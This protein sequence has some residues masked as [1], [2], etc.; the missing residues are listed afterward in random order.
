MTLGSLR[1]CISL[2]CRLP[3]V[4]YMGRSG[5]RLGYS[6]VC[7]PGSGCHPLPTSSH[8]ADGSQVGYSPVCLP[9]SG[10]HP[11]P[12][13]SHMAD[14]SQV[15]YSPVCLP[16]SGCHPPPPPL[17]TWR[18]VALYYMAMFSWPVRYAKD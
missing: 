14:G 1:D 17:H 8:M 18:T 5:Y 4:T 10:C 13:P 15:G 16:G 11:L 3:G 6:P 9:C 7:L 12:T 2:H